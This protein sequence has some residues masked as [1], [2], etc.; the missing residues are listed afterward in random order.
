MRRI[1]L[2]QLLNPK[3]PLDRAILQQVEDGKLTLSV[4]FLH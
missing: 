3:N 1:E 2:T 4:V